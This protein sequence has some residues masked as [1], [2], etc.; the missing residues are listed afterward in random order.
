MTSAH[1][2]RTARRF[3]AASRMSFFLALQSGRHLAIAR[4]LSRWS[5]DR[6]TPRPGRARPGHAEIPPVRF[7]VGTNG[8]RIQFSSTTDSYR[9]LVND[10]WQEVP[11]DLRRP[12]ALVGRGVARR[13]Q[14]SGSPVKVAIDKFCVGLVPPGETAP[15]TKLSSTLVLLLL[16]RP[17]VFHHRYPSWC[18]VKLAIPM[19]YGTGYGISAGWSPAPTAREAGALRSA[20]ACFLTAAPT[21]TTCAGLSLRLKHAAREVPH[22]R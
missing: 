16:H 21:A 11:H 10:R 6:R 3:R 1:A 19:R 8:P 20:D 17:K 18:R 22:R 9:F 12:P 13:L 7:D 15:T 4:P 5:P 14:A 2:G